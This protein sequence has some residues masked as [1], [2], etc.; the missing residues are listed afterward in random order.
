VRD[1]AAELLKLNDM[2]CLVDMKLD[3]IVTEPVRAAIDPF[4]LPESMVT[5]IK[6]MMF[7]INSLPRSETLMVA[8][9]PTFQ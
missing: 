6:E 2:H 4:K 9:E 7:P 1:G 3:I 8:D 5:L